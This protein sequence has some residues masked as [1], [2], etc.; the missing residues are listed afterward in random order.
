MDLQEYQTKLKKFTLLFSSLLFLIISTFGPKLFCLFV[1]SPAVFMRCFSIICC[2]WWWGAARVISSP[3]H[4]LHTLS[5]FL[6]NSLQGITAVFFLSSSLLI[7]NRN[8]YPK[9][10]EIDWTS[11]NFLSEWFRTLF[12]P[13]WRVGYPIGF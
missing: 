11:V 1:H 8:S 6:T 10:G 13:L 9:T 2:A 4:W 5:R 12:C 3:W 7:L